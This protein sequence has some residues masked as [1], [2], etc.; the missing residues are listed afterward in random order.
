MSL[1]VKS[2]EA[3]EHII[4]KWAEKA[5]ILNVQVKCISLVINYVH[6]LYFVERNLYLDS[7]PFSL[8]VFI[9]GPQADN[10]A[11]MTGSIFV[12]LQFH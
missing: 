11:Y 9:A 7:S 5:V 2:R 1:L 8:H 10:L 12:S 3:E 6:S 4:T